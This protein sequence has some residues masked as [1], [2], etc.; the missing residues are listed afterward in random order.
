MT[1]TSPRIA[2]VCGSLRTGSINQKLAQGIAIKI[3]AAGA[4]LLALTPEL[5]DKALSTAE[6]N[7]LEFE[8]LTDL[9]HEVATEYGLLF[10]LTPE[11][12]RLYGQFFDLKTFN[13]EDAGTDQLPLAATY[14]IGEDGK[15]LWAFL[16]HDYRKRAEPKDIVAFLK[17]RRKAK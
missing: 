8:V 16:H 2:L 5:P 15:I 6:K 14:I 11:V 9:D 13:G 1:E 3:K 4:S 7:D 17:E 10:K 12:E